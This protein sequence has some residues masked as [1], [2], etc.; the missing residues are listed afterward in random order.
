MMGC[1]FSNQHAKHALKTGVSFSF[2]FFKKIFFL[3]RGEK[4]YLV[5]NSYGNILL[6]SQKQKQ[7]KNVLLKQF[8]YKNLRFKVPCHG[9]VSSQNF[10]YGI[11]TINII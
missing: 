11:V 3:G 7:K 5:M 10:S 4:I 8:T 1:L 2:L 6:N 9:I